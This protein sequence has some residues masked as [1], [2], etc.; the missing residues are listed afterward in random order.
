MRAEELMVGCY[1]TFKDCLPDLPPPPVKILGI[2]YVYTGHENEVLAQIGRD[3]ACDIIEIDDECTGYPLTPAVLEQNGWFLANGVWVLKSSPRLG[4]NPRTKELI[5]GYYTFPAT[6]E[7]VH[8][9]QI[10]MRL[11]GV[12]ETIKL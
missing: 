12:E 4:W 7:Y 3:K 9:L 8:Q 2:G 11:L 5:T 1:I 6:I 10:L